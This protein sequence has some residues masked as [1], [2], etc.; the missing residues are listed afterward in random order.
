MKIGLFGPPG[1]GK[2]TQADKISKLYGLPHISTGALLRKNIEE[3]TQVGLVALKYIERGMLAPDEVMTQVL[4]AELGKYAD[5]FLLDGYP[6]TLAQAELLE[7]ITDLDFVLN[8]DVDPEL[9]T[10]RIVNR[11]VC[12]VC[13][14]NY[15]KRLY[16]RDVCE[17]DGAKLTTRKDDTEE[18]VKQRLNVYFKETMPII[19]YYKQKGKMIDIDGNGSIDEVFGRIEKALYDHDKKR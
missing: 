1:A 3:K 7:D 14:K 4:K 16:P 5:G 17:D 13:G 18:I 2:G 10:D 9:I 15:N 19:A 12:P 6:R 11:L 8:I